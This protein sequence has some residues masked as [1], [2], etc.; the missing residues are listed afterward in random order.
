M[1]YDKSI[2]YS[3]TCTITYPRFWVI[4]EC[5]RRNLAFSYSIHAELHAL[6]TTYVPLKFAIYLRIPQ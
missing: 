3:G 1:M 6:G 2:E 5:H 4:Q